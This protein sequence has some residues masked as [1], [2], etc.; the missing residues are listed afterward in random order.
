MP[1]LPSPFELP[2]IGQPRVKFTEFCRMIS[3][4]LRGRMNRGPG[5]INIADVDDEGILTLVYGT[6]YYKLSRLAR[7]LPRAE[8]Q[9]SL[10]VAYFG[11][12][13]GNL[14]LLVALDP[15]SEHLKVYVRG[16]VSADGT[17]P[18]TAWRPWKNDAV[19]LPLDRPLLN[20]ELAQHI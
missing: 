7:V 4:V 13:L 17:L 1:D 18:W 2:S 12:D 19:D 20:S 15:T 9:L 14:Q 5:S 11:V 3:E 6:G 10:H 8:V 16:R